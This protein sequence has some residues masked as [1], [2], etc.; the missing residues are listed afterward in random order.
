MTEFRGVGEHDQN[1]LHEI[2]RELIKMGEKKRI[3]IVLIRR[4]AAT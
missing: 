1:T 2:L 3:E 4:V